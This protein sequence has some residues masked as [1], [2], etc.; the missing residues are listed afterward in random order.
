MLFDLRVAYL[1]ADRFESR[2]RPLLVRPHQ[3]AIAGNIG[4]E[5]CFE[6]AHDPLSAHLATRV[7]KG[8]CNSKIRRDRA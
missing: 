8:I 5:D 3:P 1:A 4:H 7:R 2:K 6:P